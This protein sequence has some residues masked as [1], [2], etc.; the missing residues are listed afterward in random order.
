M[1]QISSDDRWFGSSRRRKKSEV[2]RGNRAC[3]EISGDLS[4]DRREDLCR[5]DDAERDGQKE[6]GVEKEGEG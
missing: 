1:W 4:C 2:E 5:E 6:T 3:M